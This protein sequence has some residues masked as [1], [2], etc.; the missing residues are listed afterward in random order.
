MTAFQDALVYHARAICADNT[1]TYVD[2][3]QGQT[4]IG[5]PHWDCATFN[6]YT[7]YLA[8][9]WNDWPSSSHGGIGYFWPHI[10]DT[11]FDDFLLANNWQRYSYN[12][13]LLTPG[14]II[15]TSENLHHSLM[16][17]G[18]GELA[19]ANN[20]FGYGDNS[21]AVRTFPTYDPAEFYYIYIPPD[22]TPGPGP[23]PGR[24]KYDRHR[25]YRNMGGQL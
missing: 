13:S 4:N 16:Y 24:L 19:D 2:W 22:V 18:N 10:N 5:P 23:L 15:I 20:Y 25:R 8:M 11:G 9:G 6:S 3:D 14:A 17:L 1:Q 21:I 12:A 7:I